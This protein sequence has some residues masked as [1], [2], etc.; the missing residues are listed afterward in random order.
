MT[1]RY[2]CDR[3]DLRAESSLG[4]HACEAPSDEAVQ[5]A[6]LTRLGW[7]L[8]SPFLWATGG[9]FGVLTRSAEFY[10]S[11]EACYRHIAPIAYARGYR[12]TL[13]QFGADEY[14]V[15][16]F[17]NIDRLAATALDTTPARAFARAWLRLPKE[18]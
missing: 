7:T 17:C 4:R 3:C 11:I 18:D 6:V 5:D 16:F 8:E 9:G 1:L 13:T 12:F 15:S 14:R 10:R 2:I